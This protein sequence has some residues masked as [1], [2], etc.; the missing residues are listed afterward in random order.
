MKLFPDLLCVDLVALVGEGQLE[1]PFQ[2]SGPL[3][4]QYTCP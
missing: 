1:K 3:R 4:T 2:D